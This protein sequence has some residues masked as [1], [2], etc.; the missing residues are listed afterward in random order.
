MKLMQLA[1]LAVTGSMLY[2]AP[3]APKRLDDA[4]DDLRRPRN[5]VGSRTKE[6]RRTCCSEITSAS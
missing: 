4:A 5:H 3:D 2:A 1:T 6:F